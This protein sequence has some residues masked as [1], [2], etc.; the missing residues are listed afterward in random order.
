MTDVVDACGDVVVVADP[1]VYLLAQEVCSAVNRGGGYGRPLTQ[2]GLLTR[3]APGVRESSRGARPVPGV[4]DHGRAPLNMS[5][6]DGTMGLL[7]ATSSVSLGRDQKKS[8]AHFHVLC[9]SRKKR[10]I[11]DRH[12]FLRLDDRTTLHSSSCENA[13]PSFVL[14]SLLHCPG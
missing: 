9:S 13:H 4:S 3:V 12:W 2:P 7:H 6:L 5:V 14:D 8:T 1:N 10:P 11:F